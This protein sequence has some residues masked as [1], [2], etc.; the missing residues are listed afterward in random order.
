MKKPFFIHLAALTAFVLVYAIHAT[1]GQSFKP[2]EWSD[3]NRL[4]FIYIQ[5][6]VLANVYS[7]KIKS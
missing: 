6:I 1:A 5:V 4:A 3:V 7:L 2:S